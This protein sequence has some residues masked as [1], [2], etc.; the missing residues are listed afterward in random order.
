MEGAISAKPTTHLETPRY[1][2]R[3]CLSEAGFFFPG[4]GAGLAFICGLVVG[5]DGLPDFA[6]GFA[7]GFGWP[8]GAG[9]LADGACATGGFPG[10][11]FAEGAT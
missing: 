7:E 10:T 1:F 4:F 6:G 2:F 9:A 8:V 11:P 5:A 3:F